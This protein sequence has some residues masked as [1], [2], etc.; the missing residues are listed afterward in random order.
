[1]KVEVR[2]VAEPVYP[3]ITKED[4]EDGYILRY[5]YGPKQGVTTCIVHRRPT[6]E[7]ERSLMRSGINRIIRPYG[8]VLAD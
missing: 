5:D 8:Y 7:E 3:I 1:M 4:T 2:A 6:T